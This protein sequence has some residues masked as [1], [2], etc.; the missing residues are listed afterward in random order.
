MCNKMYSVYILANFLALFLHLHLSLDLFVV[1]LIF[2]E[3]IHTPFASPG[4]A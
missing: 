4:A 1:F 2:L 3:Y